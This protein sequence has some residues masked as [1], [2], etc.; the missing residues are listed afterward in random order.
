MLIAILKCALAGILGGIIMISELEMYWQGA[1]AIIVGVVA[2]IM[3]MRELGSGEPTD[4]SGGS[5]RPVH[6]P[7]SSDPMEKQP[8]TDLEKARHLFEKVGLPFPTIPDELAAKL[9]EQGKWLF[10]TR[11][12]TTSPYNLHHF[13]YERDST[14][15]SYA[16]LSHSGHGFDSYA[17]Q[18]Y[19][20]Y[21][22]LR[23]F[24]HLGWGGAFTDSVAATS[25]IQECFSLADQIVPAAMADP[26]LA[27]GE[28]LSVV[29]SDFYGCDWSCPGQ[30]RQLQLGRF[31]HE[32]AQ[33]LTEVLRWLKNPPLPRINW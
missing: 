6:R 18:Y 30:S 28:L 27:S 21:G 22:P 24:L 16:V 26:R 31:E 4:E 12:L 8:A 32:P 5:D 15:G 7:L 13:V 25:Q 9:K 3:G 2:L 23:L 17:I 11:E 29:G 19:L 10:S 1:L 14:P 20:V 33:V